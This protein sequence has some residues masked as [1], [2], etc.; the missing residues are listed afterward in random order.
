MA[1]SAYLFDQGCLTVNINNGI[2]P[3]PH[4]LGGIFVAAGATDA[5]LDSDDDGVIDGEDNCP[6]KYNPK[7]LDADNDGVGD[8]C[9]STPGCGGLR[10]GCQRSCLCAV[11]PEAVD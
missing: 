11:V 1:L 2:T 3:A 8:V 7:Q 5:Y 4:D 9:D 10:A 6:N